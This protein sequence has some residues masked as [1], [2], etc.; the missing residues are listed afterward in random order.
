MDHP[1]NSVEEVAES[2]NPRDQGLPSESFKSESHAPVEPNEALLKI[3]QDMACVL[4]RLTAPKAPIDMIRRHGAEE[5]HRSNMEESDKAEFWL[6]KLERLMENVRCPPDQIVTCAISL[7]QGSAYDWWKLVL[8]SSRLP[9]PIS[10][11]FFVQEFKAKYVFNMYR[12]TKWK[13]F[14]NL[15]QRNLSVAKYEKEFSH[16]SK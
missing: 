12:E 4:E 11:E 15:K 2:V 10:W 5:F 3:S 7:L 1:S 8:R 9:D 14:L 13:K 6:E 16:L